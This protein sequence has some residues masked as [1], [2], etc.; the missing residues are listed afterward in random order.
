[1]ADGTGLGREV[2]SEEGLS[3]RVRPCFSPVSLRVAVTCVGWSADY[4]SSPPPWC[5]ESLPADFSFKLLVIKVVISN[6]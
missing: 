3:T 5:L 2:L 4:Y 6:Y 1:M